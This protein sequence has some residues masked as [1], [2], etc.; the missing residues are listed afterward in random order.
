M[1]L[2]TWQKQKYGE[3]YKPRMKLN[4][5]LYYSINHDLAIHLNVLFLLLQINMA[6]SI[7]HHLSNL[8]LE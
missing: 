5:F 6:I 8:F 3:V 4:S 7:F 1:F 2:A